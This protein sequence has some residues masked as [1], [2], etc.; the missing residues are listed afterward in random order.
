MSIVNDGY[1]FAIMSILGITMAMS[2]IDFSNY[3]FVSAQ[4]GNTLGQEGNGNQAFQSDE[5][6]QE[7]EQ[8]SMCVSGV[9]TSLGCNNLSTENTDSQTRGGEH[10][11]FSIQGKIY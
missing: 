4:N 1:K 2:S 6:I 11:P 9:S 7:T 8:S 10:S 3:Y 5:N